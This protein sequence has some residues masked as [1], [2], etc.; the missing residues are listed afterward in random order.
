[1]T[2]EERRAGYS[3]LARVVTAVCSALCVAILVGFLSSIQD[4]VKQAPTLAL[5]MATTNQKL[6]AI[7]NEQAQAKLAIASLTKDYTSREQLQSE[8]EKLNDKIR[9]LQVQQAVIE[10]I[11][12]SGK[13][14]TSRPGGGYGQS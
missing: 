7:E 2:I 1:M 5:H 13:A 9:A 3:R 14:G 10:M 11:L 6:E 8:L 4:L 12:K